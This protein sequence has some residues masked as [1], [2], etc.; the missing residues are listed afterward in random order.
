MMSFGQKHEWISSQKRNFVLPIYL[1]WNF[2]S[3]TNY[4]DNKF[5]SLDGASVH[6]AIKLIIF[7]DK[8]LCIETLIINNV[9]LYLD[10]I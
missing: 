6:T 8:Q 10:N 1:S 3:F 4:S 2:E 9:F 7:F 5:L